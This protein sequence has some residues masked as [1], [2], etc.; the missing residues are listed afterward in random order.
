MISP[1][2]SGELRP[3]NGIWQGFSPVNVGQEAWEAANQRATGQVAPAGGGW[4][5][6]RPTSESC[7]CLSQASCGV[8]HCACQF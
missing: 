2:L 5:P 7:F 8:G 1:C 3:W 4:L 6:L